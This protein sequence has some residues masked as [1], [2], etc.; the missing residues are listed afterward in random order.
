MS[1]SYYWSSQFAYVATTNIF[2][3]IAFLSA[4]FLILDPIVFLSHTGYDFYYREKAGREP[5]PSTEK[6]GGRGAHNRA[7]AR[8]SQP[9]PQWWKWYAVSATI[10]LMDAWFFRTIIPFYERASVYRLSG[11]P[12]SPDDLQE[13]SDICRLMWGIV[14]A[15]SLFV[16]LIELWEK[17]L[18]VKDLLGKDYKNPKWAFAVSYFVAPAIIA[19]SLIPVVIYFVLF[20]LWNST[21]FF[22]NVVTEAF[23]P[24][25]R[26][27][28]DVFTKIATTTATKTIVKIRPSTSGTTA[29]A[30]KYFGVF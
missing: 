25:W 24:D 20:G 16:I 6:R 2:N 21:G 26:K 29:T 23:T 17:R 11:Q 7:D 22:W 19:I 4:I 1:I 12:P 28:Q 14:R 30:K 13:F 18:V 8:A 10:H 5:S 9:K 15:L 3:F 27:G